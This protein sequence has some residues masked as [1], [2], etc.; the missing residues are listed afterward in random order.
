M[1]D[2]LGSSRYRL[3]V[4]LFAFIFCVFPARRVFSVQPSEESVYMPC[5]QFTEGSS[6]YF[7][8]NGGPLNSV[9]ELTVLRRRDRYITLLEK[10][11]TTLAV[12]DIPPYTTID[13]METDLEE[14]GDV[15]YFLKSVNRDG[16]R[17]EAIRSAFCGR[18]P[19]R[20]IIKSKLMARDGTILSEE[21]EVVRRR[22]LGRERVVVPAGTFDAFVVEEVR[23]DA[24]EEQE[25]Q[26][27][28]KVVI[29]SFS[30]EGV[31]V[32]RSIQKGFTPVAGVYRY[33]G[34]SKE[35][36]DARGGGRDESVRPRATGPGEIESGSILQK[37]VLSS[38]DGGWKI[39]RDTI[40][41]ELQHFNLK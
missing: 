20:E 38:D 41:S 33:S 5:L 29:I 3:F 34:S 18:M 10:T 9:T 31:G 6:T 14:N 11:T 2:F 13:V 30:A 40:I 21:K 7:V 16:E 39:V 27:G 37:R 32:V 36:T 23:V 25:E 12:S 17:F 28:Q 4:L 15:V 26:H 24:G 22:S 35:P 1:N 8:D 19:V